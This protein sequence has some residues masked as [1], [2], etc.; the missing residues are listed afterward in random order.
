MGIFGAL[1]LGFIA[2][3]IIGICQENNNVYKKKKKDKE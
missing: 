2:A 3:A 1:L